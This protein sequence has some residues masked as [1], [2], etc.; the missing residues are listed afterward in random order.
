[1]ELSRPFRA[2]KLWLSLRYYGLRA[3]QESIREDLRLAQVLADSI[4]AESRLERLAPVALSAVCFRY[5]GGKNIDDL[6]RSILSRVMRRGHVYISNAIIHDK[7]ALRACIVN[8][9][10]TEDD[11]RSVVSEVLASADEMKQQEASE[12]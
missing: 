5:V 11:V 6:N 2:L 7:F 3:F 1:M 4:D 9:R 12:G 8:H 10:S